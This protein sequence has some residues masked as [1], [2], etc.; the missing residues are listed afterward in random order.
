[1]RKLRRL[2]RM[3]WADRLLI[4]ESTLLLAIMRAA[5]RLFPLRRILGAFGLRPGKAAT[6]DTAVPEAARRVA[7]AIRTVSGH[8]P[9]D[10]NCLAQALAGS[11]M[12][13]RRGIAGTLYLGV[14]KDADAGLEAHAWLRSHERT[15]TGGGGLD[16]YTVVAS[17]APAA[18]I[19]P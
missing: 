11:V 18:S 15:L 12:L 19:P 10:S 5:V 3:S 17:F 16:R 1:M 2:A 14:A 4:A 13:K 6:P 7:L 9:W 8:T